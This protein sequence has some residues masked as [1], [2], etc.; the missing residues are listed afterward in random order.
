MSNEKVTFFMGDSPSFFSKNRLLKKSAA[1]F[2]LKGRGC[3]EH[4]VACKKFKRAKVQKGKVAS[5]KSQ[6][7]VHL[8]TRK[9][10]NP[11]IRFKLKPEQAGSWYFCLS[12]LAL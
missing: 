5:Q 1:F 2:G 3:Q 6:D 7:S 12:D 9:C 11:Y 10:Q 8:Y 4:T